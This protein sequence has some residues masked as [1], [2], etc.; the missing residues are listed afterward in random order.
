M[1]K[2]SISS[3]FSPA[4]AASAGGDENLDCCFVCGMGGTLYMCDHC[5]RAYHK[6]CL[7]QLEQTDIKKEMWACSHCCHGRDSFSLNDLDLRSPDPYKL[8]GPCSGRAGGVSIAAV[9]LTLEWKMDDF[10]RAAPDVPKIMSA[11]F[12]AAEKTSSLMKNS[13]QSLQYQQLLFYVRRAVGSD[14]FDEVWES[15]ASGKDSISIGLAPSPAF[16]TKGCFACQR[17]RYFNTFCHYCAHV[18]DVKAELNSFLA[19][20]AQEVADFPMPFEKIRSRSSASKTNGT[21]IEVNSPSRHSTDTVPPVS[22]SSDNRQLRCA[23]AGAKYLHSC[24]TK[25]GKH[26][27]DDDAFVTH[28]GDMMFLMR[29]I[30]ACTLQSQRGASMSY[31][32]DMLKKWSSRNVH[33]PIVFEEPSTMLN[34]MEGLHVVC[35]LLRKDSHLHSVFSS[36]AVP[37]TTEEMR[38]ET[39]TDPPNV[40]QRNLG[41]KSKST[42]S[43]SPELNASATKRRCTRLDSLREEMSTFSVDYESPPGAEIAPLDISGLKKAV[44]RTLLTLHLSDIMGYDPSCQQLPLTPKSHCS[45][46]SHEVTKK[47]SRVK[48][49][50]CNHALKMKVDYGSLTDAVVWAY[51]FHDIGIPIECH[52]GSTSLSEVVKILPL[53]RSYQRIDELGHNF[54]RLQCYFLTHLIYVFSDWGQHALRR[55]LFAD[56]FEFIV[57]NMT[58]A[59]RIDDPEV[60]AEFIQCLK[61]LQVT[62]SSDPDVWT[63]I[64]LGYKY[65]IGKEAEKGK[66]G[67]GLWVGANDSLYNRYHSSYCASI[68]LYDYHFMENEAVRLRPPRPR[69]LDLML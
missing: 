14:L 52:D 62:P 54:Y 37:P 32:Q 3:P 41:F 39:L 61:I 7:S 9:I 40:E 35:Q 23:M 33:V 43:A 58:L 53:A 15:I 30:A 2:K 64:E 63:L 4:S 22:S 11:Y 48:C 57:R 44:E 17:T 36:H 21:Q 59:I 1:S 12:L 66:E 25:V 65:L 28:G 42:T 69:L 27:D 16:M 49:V 46:C 34:F 8:V 5:I 56:E 18:H 47:E 10:L 68:A 24:S 51:V 50:K 67:K 26:G 29:N 20:V 55:Q 60:V 45:N 19:E 31:L 6:N 38:E 13:H